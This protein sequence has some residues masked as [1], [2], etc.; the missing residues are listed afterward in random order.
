[1]LLASSVF[2]LVAGC[3]ES[4]RPLGPP[5]GALDPGLVGSWR[6]VPDAEPG[7][8]KDF[9][10]LLVVPFDRSQYYLE[11]REE[12]KIQRHRAYATQVKDRTLYNVVEVKSRGDTPMWRFLRATREPDSRLLLEVVDGEAVK[13]KDEAAAL[14]EI[15]RRIDDGALYSR[16]A[17]CTFEG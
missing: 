7:K 8:P 10:H 12:S 14:D 15:R 1:M 3:Y 16:W 13:A 2:L 17:V 9:A 6:C 11:W 4:S 5:E